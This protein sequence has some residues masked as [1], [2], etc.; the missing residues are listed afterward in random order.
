MKN[1]LIHKNLN[2]LFNKIPI[3]KL[4]D[5]DRF[6]IFSDL[7]MGNGSKRD[8]FMQNADMFTYVL[9]N[10]Y[11]K[12]NYKLILNGDIEELYRFTLK[13]IILKWKDIY[14][15]FNTFKKKGALLKT[16][17]NH[18]FKLNFEKLPN[19]DNGVLE[20]IKLDYKGNI[21]FIFHGHQ[22]SGILMRH[23]NFAEFILRYIANPL[24]IRNWE[25]P[26][27]SRRKFKTEKN[28][29]NF[30][31]NNKIIAIIGHTHR[32]LFQSLS[33]IDSLRFKVEQLCRDFQIADKREKNKI[34]SAVNIYKN[35]LKYYYNKKHKKERLQSSL[36]SPKFN[37]PSLFNSGCVI[38]KRGITAIE[39]DKGDILLTHWFD[40]KKRD[41]YLNF[42]KPKPEC[43]NKSSYYRMIFNR[44]S[45]DYIFTRI[46]LLT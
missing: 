15:I 28:V 35:E 25:V 42:T 39:I 16:I 17:G 33:K 4:S 32:P 2:K 43:L 8:D 36:Y 12:K 9:K 31:Y 40:K 41:K 26:F 44:D 21:I 7:H 46:K 1:T 6:V 38:G 29:Y 22:A 13:K 30:S 14:K 37:V 45:L 3:Q 5:K 18:D 11:Y 20:A 24:M 10:Y 34:I 23:S 27:N 19:Q